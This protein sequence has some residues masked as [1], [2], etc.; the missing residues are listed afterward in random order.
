M[1]RKDPRGLSLSM[2]SQGS[3]GSRGPTGAGENRLAPSVLQVDV[4]LEFVVVAVAAA[5][6][7]ARGM[8]RPVSPRFEHTLVIKHYGSR[9]WMDC[10][11]TE[12]FARQSRAHW[13]WVAGLGGGI[14]LAD[15]ARAGVPGAWT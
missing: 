2:R 5:G 14:H 6:R 4:D 15:V 12:D 11:T 8:A 10:W 7:V 13:P 9:L 3:A 1:D